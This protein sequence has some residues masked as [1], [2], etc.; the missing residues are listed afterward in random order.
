MYKLAGGLW[1]SVRDTE[2]GPGERWICGCY[3]LTVTLVT[4]YGLVVRALY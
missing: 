4:G 2:E 1:V 3:A